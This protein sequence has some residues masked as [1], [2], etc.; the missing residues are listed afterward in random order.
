MSIRIVGRRNAFRSAW[1]AACIALG[2][3]AHAQVATAPPTL[4]PPITASA[5]RPTA[6]VTVP[7]MVAISY[8]VPGQNP[9]TAATS[10]APSSWSI[11]QAGTQTA[12]GRPG[13]TGNYIDMTVSVGNG[14]PAP[15]IPPQTPLT[16][17]TLTEYKA[18]MAYATTSFVQAI[19]VSK[20]LSPGPTAL[21]ESLRFYFT[22]ATT[23]Y[24]N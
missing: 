19:L 22:Q 14:S 20:S 5:L 10:F 8:P 4:K 15:V 13:A 18:G 21:Q 16:S 12:V 2:A 7:Y 6:V 9:P 17:M 1:V 24:A 3:S 11:T 23:T